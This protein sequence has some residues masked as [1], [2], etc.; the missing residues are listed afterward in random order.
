MIIYE[1]AGGRDKDKAR[2]YEP[3][4]NIADKSQLNGNETEL[5]LWD[6]AWTQLSA[7]YQTVS[8]TVAWTEFPTPLQY[9][10]PAYDLSETQY[11]AGDQVEINL[12]I[13][14]CA[15]GQD[16]AEKY[17]FVP[18]CN[19]VNDSELTD[20]EK[21][22]WDV[23][24]KPVCACYK[25]ETPTFMPSQHPSVRPTER[26]TFPPSRTPTYEPSKSPSKRPTYKPSKA[27]SN[28]P[29]REVSFNLSS[30]PLSFVLY[31]FDPHHCYVIPFVIANQ[32]AIF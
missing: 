25:T 17:K 29:T 21:E 9:C 19:M 2:I 28:S 1:C 26:P 3:Y 11:K 5:E 4:C 23:A 15:G 24:W 6:E 20:D 14:E 16:E 18:Y 7:C 32:Q 12:H 31:V 10:P 13:F 27:P 22:L 30:I 8:P